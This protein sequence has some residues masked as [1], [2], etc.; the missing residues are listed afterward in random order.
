M[1]FN[2]LIPEL[3]V[4]NLIA[5]LNFYTVLL[6]FKI[7]YERKEKKFAFISYEGSQIMLEENSNPNWNTGDLDYPFGRG[8]NF[9]IDVSN[10]SL[11]FE[12]LKQ[13]K[14]PIK[15]QPHENWYNQDN[16]LLGVKEFLVMDP[17][18]YLLRFSQSIG[19]KDAD[20]AF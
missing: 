10:V 1:K 18:G 9:Q 3:R 11:L 19:T 15:V 5:S 4:S 17:D 8:I 12:R 2:K 6:N 20:A 13:G 16:K 7:E 14:Y